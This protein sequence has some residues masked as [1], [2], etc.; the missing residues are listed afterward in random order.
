MDGLLL[1]F[2]TMSAERLSMEQGREGCL[3][4]GTS[5]SL[6]GSLRLPLVAA[7]FC[8]VYPDYHAYQDRPA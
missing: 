6:R 5:G 8:W 7:L 4:L 2:R 3:Y 1:Q